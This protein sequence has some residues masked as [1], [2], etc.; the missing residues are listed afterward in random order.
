[1]AGSASGSDGE[2]AGEEEGEEIKIAQVYAVTIGRHV[3]YP[4]IQTADNHTYFK[5]DK[6][7]R[8]LTKIVMGKGMQRHTKTNKEVVSLSSKAFWN[9][10]MQNRRRACNMAIKDLLKHNMEQAGQEVPPNHKFRDARDDDRWLVHHGQVKMTLPP[11]QDHGELV[12]KALWQV[13][14]ALW[15]E[16]RPETVMHCIR[17]LRE[18]EDVVHRSPKRKRKK[19]RGSQSATPPKTRRAGAQALAEDAAAAEASAPEG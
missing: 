9:D 12:F 7:D 18:S 1:M 4:D 5:L 6:S 3:W 11:V 15:L 10:M 8:Q 19:K 2:L 14:G 16:L 13:K 17:L